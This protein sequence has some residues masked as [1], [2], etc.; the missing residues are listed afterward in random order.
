MHAAMHVFMHALGRVCCSAHGAAHRILCPLCDGLSEP[1]LAAQHQ[2]CQVQ[3]IWYL[4]LCMLLC[5]RLATYFLCVPQVHEMV[6]KALEAHGSA[7]LAQEALQC[8]KEALRMVQE[9]EAELQPVTQAA[10]QA[11][12]VWR[13]VHRARCMNA[14]MRRCGAG[15]PA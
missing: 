6:C 5:S 12:G 1:I 9:S 10:A 3:Q 2:I 8:A 15:M 13:F 14:C 11:S 4:C 7:A